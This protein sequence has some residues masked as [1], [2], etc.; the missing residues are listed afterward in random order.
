MRQDQRQTAPRRW[1]QRRLCILHADTSAPAAIRD[2][3]ARTAFLET[4]ARPPLGARVRLEHKEAGII[5]CEVAGLARDGIAIS[6]PGDAR[7]VG[8]ALAVIA[9]DMSVPAG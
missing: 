2:I 3:N 4:N 7:A 9:A 1:R 5:C 6:L 8:F